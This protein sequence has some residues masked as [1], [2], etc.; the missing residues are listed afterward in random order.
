MYIKYLVYFNKF[1]NYIFILKE[2]IQFYWI[3]YI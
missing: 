3:V 1:R 2:D